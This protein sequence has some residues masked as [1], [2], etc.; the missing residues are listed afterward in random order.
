M[1]SSLPHT[2]FNFSLTF[3]LPSVNAANLNKSENLPIGKELTLYQMTE[4]NTSLNSK[5]LKTTK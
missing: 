5:H 1:Y 3:I 2:N 4:S